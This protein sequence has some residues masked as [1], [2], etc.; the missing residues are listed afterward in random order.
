MLTERL[1]LPLDQRPP[2]RPRRR[3]MRGQDPSNRLLL[4]LHLLLLRSRPRQRKT[5]FILP[6]RC[7]VRGSPS[8]SDRPAG[9]GVEQ[10]HDVGDM[11]LKQVLLVIFRLL[12]LA[13]E[14]RGG[15]RGKAVQLCGARKD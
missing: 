9:G 13:A 15:V 14:D 2:R 7:L 8:N 3:L 6:G 10:D 12:T 1:P 11:Q 5:H 4:H